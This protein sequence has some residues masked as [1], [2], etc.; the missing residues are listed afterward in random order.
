MNFFP[1]PYRKINIAHN[2]AGF[3]FC[4]RFGSPDW[5]R[6]PERAVP[7][8]SN[9]GLNADGD[10]EHREE[11]DGKGDKADFVGWT[12][13]GKRIRKEALGKINTNTNKYR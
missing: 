1:P 2:L 11:A 7:A 4:I 13:A 10:R 6:P 3:L 8:V 5:T 9:H 12:L